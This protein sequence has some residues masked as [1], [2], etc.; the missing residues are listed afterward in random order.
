MIS[1]WLIT[2]GKSPIPGVVGPLPNGRTLWLTNRGRTR[3]TCGICERLGVNAVDPRRESCSALFP[4]GLT[5]ALHFWTYLQNCISPS[6][7]FRP[8]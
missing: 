8:F 4:N 1:K 6:A 2:I 3:G 5:E 7:P